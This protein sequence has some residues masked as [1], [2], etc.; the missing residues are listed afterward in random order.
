MFRFTID[1]PDKL[2]AEVLRKF[3]DEGLTETFLEELKISETFVEEEGLLGRDFLTEKA[4][5]PIQD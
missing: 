4:D 1:C 2:S 3:L 5:M